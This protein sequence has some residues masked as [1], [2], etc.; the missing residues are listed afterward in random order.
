MISAF[1]DAYTMKIHSIF[2]AATFGFLCGAAQ[3]DVK[4]ARLFADHTVLQRDTKVPI[5]G[6]AEPGEQVSVAIGDDNAA[7]VADA[8]GAWMVTL[9]PRPASAQ[10]AD[11]VVTGKNKVTVHDCLV[12]DVWL[13]SGQSNMEM[14]FFWNEQGKIA[15]K[16]VDAP[17]IRIFKVKAAP[18]ETPQTTLDQ[19]GWTVCI[20][21]N[22]VEY[23]SQLGYY[24]AHELQQKLGIPIGII[25]SSCSGTSIQG[26]I[27]AQAL[28]ADPAAPAVMDHWQKV[29]A[30]YPAKKTAYEQAKAAW[31][32]EKAAAQKEGK[33]FTKQSPWPP[34]GPGST[35]GPS[36]LYNSLIH[37][38]IPYGLRGVVWYQGENNTKRPD[39]YRTLFPSL[40]RSWRDALGQG[41]LP[42][43]WVQL[44]NYNMGTEFGDDW[45]GL[46]EAQ[47]MALSL[48][49]TGQAV[50]I[51][52]GQ[53]ANIHPNNKAEVARRLA[54][55]A[56]ARTYGDKTVIDSGPV[57]EHA[58]FQ[59]GEP[60]RIHFKLVAA[61]LK[62]K[63]VDPA[64]DLAGFELAGEDKVF[65]PAEAHIDG[66]TNTVLVSSKKVPAPVAA[67]YA[68]HNNPTGLTLTN[69][70]DLP[71]APFRTDNWQGPASK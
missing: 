41:D 40:I 23:V 13:A 36:V 61:G 69:S 53:A 18:K 27:S 39:L 49:N 43:Y 59:G 8:Q 48:A 12:G 60:V 47:A 62:N 25:D 21:K 4:L 20:P 68:W 6:T 7:T 70:Q 52:I 51:D 5:W 63:A 2:L 64:A 19:G 10:P 32:A 26:W 24:F 1:N 34:N 17:L 30:D 35:Q 50:T 67:R 28:A 71:L 15:A 33:P 9:R 37:P 46:R 57:F 31:E 11:L 29:L 65:Y 38:L 44:P 54:L 55:I 58:D 3:A 14:A 45:A 56:F 66:V 42:F 16:A 22:T